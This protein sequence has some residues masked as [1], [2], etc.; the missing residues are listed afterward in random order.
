ML[1]YKIKHAMCPRYL[2]EMFVNTSKVR[3][4]RTRSVSND[5][6]YIKRGASNNFNKTFAKKWNS[7]QCALKDSPSLVSFKKSCKNF[8]MDKIK[9]DSFNY[10]WIL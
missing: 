6:M 10:G 8:L 9:M 1:M 5:A 3:T 4:H 2:Q 7:L